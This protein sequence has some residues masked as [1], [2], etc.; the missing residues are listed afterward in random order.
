MPAFFT[1]PLSQ[2]TTHWRIFHEESAALNPREEKSDFEELRGRGDTRIYRHG[3]ETLA[4]STERGKT[5]AKLRRL[6][7]LTPKTGCVLL[8]HDALLDTVAEAIG[9]KKRRQVT[10]EQRERLISQLGT[11]AQP[12]NPDRTAQDNAPKTDEDA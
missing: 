3:Q 8:F 4:V 7:G 12:K 11:Y 2:L 6:P 1:N 9:A 10:E 5:Y